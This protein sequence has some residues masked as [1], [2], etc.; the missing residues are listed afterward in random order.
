[1]SAL[2]TSY[3][4]SVLGSFENAGAVREEGG[5]EVALVQI[6]RRTQLRGVDVRL[7]AAECVDEQPSAQ[8]HL[9]AD[10]PGNPQALG[11]GIENRLQEHAGR[12]RTP[13][14]V[15]LHPLRRDHQRHKQLPPPH[16]RSVPHAARVLARTAQRAG[17]SPASLRRSGG[18]RTT[19][20]ASAPT[21]RDGGRSAPIS[22]SAPM[23][24]RGRTGPGIPGIGRRSTAGA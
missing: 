2:S 12:L 4:R 21:T 20:R 22:A 9:A 23:T 24:L 5:A 19:P 8:S 14:S 7:P 6:E 16:P 3:I 10:R 1:M 18:T 11:L 13:W 17:S 15:L